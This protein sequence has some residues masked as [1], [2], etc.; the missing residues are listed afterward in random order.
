MRADFEI[1]T[2]LIHQQTR[3]SETKEAQYKSLHMQILSLLKRVAGRGER[4]E[5][6][7][8]SVPKTD[9]GLFNT[10][11]CVTCLT[12]ARWSLRSSLTCRRAERGS[13][14]HRGAQQ[15]QNSLWTLKELARASEQKRERQNSQRNE[16]AGLH[17]WKIKEQ[18]LAEEFSVN[19]I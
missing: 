7:P 13:T 1:Q 3:K 16:S 18:P 9:R 8:G 4:E 11:A 5:A 10:S 2:A 15:S 14:G 19:E 17:L 12:A 6:L